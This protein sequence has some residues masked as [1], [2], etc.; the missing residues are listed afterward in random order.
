MITDKY[1]DGLFRTVIRKRD[2]YNR[3]PVCNEPF[4]DIGFRTPE[5]GHFVKRR[6]LLTRW[7]LN[8]AVLICHWCNY[9]DKDLTSVLI[10]RGVDP[11]ELIR[12]SRKPIK[13]D[14]FAIKETLIQQLNEI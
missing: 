4:E 10:S 7:N 6:F 3:C 14:K 8:N 9:M 5:V 12:T 1:L 13:V 11:E 2:N